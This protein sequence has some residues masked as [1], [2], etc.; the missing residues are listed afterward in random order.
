M[1]NKYEKALEKT[2]KN[3]KIN[4]SFSISNKLFRKFKKILSTPIILLLNLAFV[5]SKFLDIF[6]ISK[7]FPIPK[8]IVKPM[9]IIIDQYHSYPIAVKLLKK[10]FMIDFMFLENN[11]IFINTSLDL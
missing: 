4:G 10:L 6:Q 7:F 8:R 9:L 11:N 5:K 1:Q 3:N 2:L